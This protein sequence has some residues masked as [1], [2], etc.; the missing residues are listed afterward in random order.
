MCIVC[1]CIRPSSK[2]TLGLLYAEKLQSHLQHPLQDTTLPTS[3]SR[4]EPFLEGY[5]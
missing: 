4:E 2:N 3:A 1:S 5:F